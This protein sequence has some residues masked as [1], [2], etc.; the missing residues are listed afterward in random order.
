MSTVKPAAAVLLHRQDGRV[1]WVRRGEQLRFAGGFYAF[2]GGRVDLDDAAVPLINGDH[3]G[4][5]GAPIVVAAA[6]ELFEETGVLAVPKAERISAAERKQARAG[7][8]DGT[9]SFAALL[10]RHGLRVDA[11]QFLPAGRWVTPPSMPVR[12][13]A[14]F[15]LVELPPGEHAEVWPGELADGEWILPAGALARWESGSALLHPPA[16]HSLKALASVTS[17]REALPLLVD[18]SRAPWKLPVR[19]GVVQ[20]IEFQRGVVLVPLRTPTLPPATH[21]NCLLLG[22]DALWVVD[23]GSPYPEEQEI[24]RRTLATL[25]SEGRHAV[26]ILLTHHHHDH[27]AGAATLRDELRLP[28]AATAETAALLDGLRVDKVLADGDRLDVG[29]RGWR[30]LHLPGHTRGHLCLIENESGAVIAGDLIAGTGTVVIDPPEGDMKD[31]LRS[32]DRLLEQKPGTIYPAHGPV[33]PTGIPRIETYVQH[34]LERE[35]RVVES[36]AAAP[37]PATPAQLV[38]GAYPDISADLYPLAER[39]L[40]AH[41]I[42]LVADGRAL[43]RGGLY[44]ATRA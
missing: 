7:L 16:W 24:L 6:R 1:F 42:K 11:G 26:G 5:L 27:V 34:R 4:P 21:T 43:E 23:P 35:R 39:S 37:A 25:A 36:L 17:A 41:L 2:P 18:P 3:L 14:R 33:I 38:P 28:I 19:E 32:L 22:D 13:D 12:F 10:A 30:C 40:L 8:L 29:P 44:E 15:F 20:R 9:L 31:Y